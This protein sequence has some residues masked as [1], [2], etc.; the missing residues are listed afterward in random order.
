MN[1]IGVIWKNRAIVWAIYFL[2]LLV[3][4]AAQ[5]A[6]NSVTNQTP[7]QPADNTGTNQAPE[8]GIQGNAT[9]V[10]PAAVTNTY[11]AQPFP[12]AFEAQNNAPIVAGPTFV[13][14][15]QV[16]LPVMGT[17]VFGVPGFA[18]ARGPG[19]YQA[20][21]LNVHVGLAYSFLY[22][23]GIEAQ[24]GERSATVEHVV[25]P[26]L[27]IDLGTH[28]TLAYSAALS[29]YSGNA[30]LTDSTGQF[31]TLSGGTTYEGWAFGLSQSYSLSSTPLIETG[32]QTEEEDYVTALSVSRQLTGGFSITVGLN[33]S[34]RF[35]Q[36]FNDV[37]EWSANGAINYTLSPKLQVGLNV[38]GGYDEDSTS[39]NLTFETYQ[40]ILMFNPGIKTTVNL[41]GGIQEESFDISGVPA[42]TS[43]IFSASIAYQILK[44]TSI[45]L[46]AGRTVSPTF[47]SNQVETATTV[48]VGLLQHL[49]QKLNLSVT[50]SY[51][52]SSYQ[53]IEPGPLPKY[54]L[55]IP[56]TTPLQ[57][58]RNDVI[59][60]IGANLS[61]A[62]R[63]RLNGS[64]S[65][66]YGE[67]SSSQDAF[68][69]SSSQ[70][71]VQVS[72]QY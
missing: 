71:T 68:S 70:F 13:G 52:T 65:Y 57:V 56:T 15:G 18:P 2:G 37:H 29:Y 43:P 17:G 45:S 16:N 61:Y 54:F 31:V 4:A 47:F 27:T 23:T 53:S 32:T 14:A 58:T 62:F 28:W 49:S 66:S 3:S 6:D 5:P 51:G 63:P 10:L 24:P 69:Y 42:S 22:G 46:N 60:Y 36:Q 11:G 41:S 26:S 30:N 72:Y 1:M 21:L 12:T 19:V 39:P 33:Q 55:G 9:E 67:N 7:A 59:T 44:D 40:G 35:A 64:V 8:E 34:F 25:A 50:G 48:G 20:G 38:G